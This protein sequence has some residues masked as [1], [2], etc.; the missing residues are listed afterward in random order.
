MSSEYDEF[1][2]SP[3]DFFELDA[4]EPI[5]F[6]SDIAKLLMPD[7]ID[8]DPFSDTSSFGRPHAS[9]PSSP[10]SNGLSLSTSYTSVTSALDSTCGCLMQALECM[11]IFSSTKPPACVLSNSLDS[12]AT[13]SN[14]GHSGH[15][16]AQAVVLENKK[17]IEAVSNMLHCS[18]AE[19]A[20]LLTMLSMIIFKILGR[21]A[22]AARKQPGEATE[23]REKASRNA[24]SKEQV[25]LLSSYCPDD[26]DLGRI[27]AQL[28]LSELHR[29]QRLVNQLSPRLKTRGLGASGKAGGISG[30]KDAGGDSQMSSPSDDEMTAAPFSATTLDQIE[31]DLRKCLSTLSSEIISMLQN[32]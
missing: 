9:K 11:K 5:N 2:T 31:I 7:D 18:C 21:Y 24:S 17:T 4:R 29:V 25:R 14:L 6:T 22:V 12:A 23:R 3:I 30:V 19:D 16:S 8:L 27:A 13:A 28:I 1:Y 26:E 15:P 20:Y 32:S 10:S